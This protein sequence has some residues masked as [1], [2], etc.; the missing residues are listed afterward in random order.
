MKISLLAIL[1][2]AGTAVAQQQQP[3]KFG[4]KVD[5]NLV[6]LDA[7]VTD[8]RGNQILGLDKDDFIVTEGG[9]PQSIDSVEYFT[10][11]KLLTSPEQK[12]AF[13]VERIR[14]DRYYV[15]FFDKP[16]E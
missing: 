1:L 4:E 5:V 2:A 13:K 6:M 16:P 12:A 7:I 9:K 3:G 10:N 8:H 15:F 11:R 14:D